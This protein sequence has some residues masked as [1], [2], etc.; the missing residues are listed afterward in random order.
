MADYTKADGE[1]EGFPE[2]GHIAMLVGIKD[3]YYYVAEELWGGGTGYVGAVIK[4]Y[5]YNSFIYYFYWH[6]NMDEFY[7]SDGYLTDYWL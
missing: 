6:I 2:G 3:G 5:D 1:V 7:G 4:K